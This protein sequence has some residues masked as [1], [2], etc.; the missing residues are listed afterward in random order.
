M[1][2]LR[3][4][5]AA[6]GIAASGVALAAGGHH[7]VDDASLIEPGH[8]EIEGWHTRAQGGQR[9]SHAGLGCGVGPVELG[10]STEHARDS[11]TG[12]TAQGVQLKWARE[13][14]PHISAGFSI[15]GNWAAQE[16]PSYQGTTVSALMTWA[17][18]DNIHLHVNVGRDFLRSQP[19]SARSGVAL[20]WSPMSEAWL[21]AAERYVEGRTPFSRV[22]LRWH[23]S[24]RTTLDVSRAQKLGDPRS[25]SWTV[26][27]TWA[28][29]R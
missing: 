2:A 21:L 25:S 28:F 29:Q 19:G 20:D 24:S 6:A 7:T 8:C 26:A 14:T 16:H 15:T 18:R 27:A 3:A 1:A 13:W 12:S 23:A 10:L 17:L 9:L 5:V 4:L 22:G 11:G